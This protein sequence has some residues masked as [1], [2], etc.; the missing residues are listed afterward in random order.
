MLLFLEVLKLFWGEDV[1]KIVHD[2]LLDVRARPRSNVVVEGDE[3]ALKYI[4][5]LKICFGAAFV[6]LY[7]FIEIFS[8]TFDVLKVAYFLMDTGKA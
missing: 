5:A 1:F 2:P 4:E 8:V 3:V 6:V 7:V